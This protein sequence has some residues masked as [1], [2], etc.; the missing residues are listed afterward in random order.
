MVQKKDTYTYTS[1]T[2]SN[3][4]YFRLYL[5]GE[6][7]DQKGIYISKEDFRRIK[8]NTPIQ[9]TYYEKVNIAVTGWYENEK[10]DFF[11]IFCSKKMEAYQNVA[12]LL[13]ATLKKTRS[14]DS[15]MNEYSLV[16]GHIE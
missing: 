12:I 7:G 15:L 16:L 1:D 5:L 3:S 13:S 11:S 14:R 9:L 2:V 6:H 4:T 10:L 8:E